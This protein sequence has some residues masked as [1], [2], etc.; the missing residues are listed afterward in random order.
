MN[1]V[2]QPSRKVK[3]FQWAVIELMN[4]SNLTFQDIAESIG[5]TPI[6]IELFIKT[7]VDWD[8]ELAKIL[9]KYLNLDRDDYDPAIFE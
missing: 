1:T 2:N 6:N 4:I 3:S 5:T 9:C 7:S 8:K